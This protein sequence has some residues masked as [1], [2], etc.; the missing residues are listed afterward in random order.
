MKR[1]WTV[2]EL[3]DH[4]TL[5]VDELS[6][7]A[8]ART[9]SNQLGVAL[10]LKWFQHEGQF[11]KRKQDVPLEVIDFLAQQ[12]NV[13]PGMFKSYPL[14]GRTV[15]RHRAQIRQYLGFRETTVQ[16]VETITQWLIES[17]LPHQRQEVA[18]QEAIYDR[19]R[20]QRMEPPTP[21]RIERI[22][23]SALR[24]ADEQFYAETMAKLSSTTR[25]HLDALLKTTYTEQDTDDESVGRS[26][27]HDLKQ[28]AGAIKVDTLLAE[29]DKL[30]QI[31]NLE[32]PAEVLL[33]IILDSS[34]VCST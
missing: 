1:R 30:E 22:I 17:V 33:Q 10:L 12:L 27:L 25:I 18:L 5:H 32:L 15:E 4:W 24:T 16:D 26:M 34:N 7:A 6:M 19:C 29:I 8:S 11:P 28:G 3:V 14:Q 23:R 9:A 31:E 20:D 21:Q 2:D 13:E